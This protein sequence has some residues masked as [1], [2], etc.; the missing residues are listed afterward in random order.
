MRIA[1]LGDIALFGCNTIKNHNYTKKFAGIKEVLDKCDYVIGNLETP[2]TTSDKTIGGKS[3]YI[4]GLPEN[5]N[6]LKYLNVTHVGLAN[7]HAFDY[8]QRGLTE[9]INTLDKA[10]ISW[11]GV[12]GKQCR[13]NIDDNSIALL[14]YCCYSTNGK[15]M[16]VVDILDPLIIEKE[17]NE[18]GEVLP[19]LSLHWGQEHVHYPNYDHLKIARK[20]CENR[21]L[22][23]H[24]HHPHVIQGVERIGNSIVAYSLGNFC[25]DDIYTSKSKDPLVRLSEDNM[26]SFVMILNIQNNN[27]IDYEIIPFCFNENEYTNDEEIVEKIE[28]WSAFLQTPQDEYIKKRNEDISQYINNRKKLRNVQWYLKRMSLESIKMI[29]SAKTN[30]KKYNALIQNYIS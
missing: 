11:Y 19:I 30:L 4:K 2:L 10:G 13:I 29:L 22:V 25:F 5:V 7:N 21:N 17:L 27:I 8:G 12:N 18:L 1:L 14:G 3:A 15:G 6:I 16:G 28:R 23:I 24:G 26:E 20:L 9:T